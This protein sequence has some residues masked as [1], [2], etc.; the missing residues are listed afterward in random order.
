MPIHVQGLHKHYPGA[1]L[2]ALAGVSLTVGAGKIVALVGKSGAGKSTLLRCLVGLESFDQGTV[3][4]D[5]LRVTASGARGPTALVGKVGLVF[6]SFELFP[7]L[8]V[9]DNC[10]LALR[11]VQLSPRAKAEAKVRAVLEEL[12]LA[13]K[14]GAAPEL[15]S[16]GQKQRVALAR[17]LVLEPRALVYDEPT[18]ALDPALKSEVARLLRK[19]AER[20]IAQVVVTHDTALVREAAD[21]VYVLEAGRVVEEGEPRIL[22]LRG[23]R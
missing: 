4:V 7:H 10:T 21:W 22:E 19:V 20:Q 15:L 2:P 3:D 9:L 17:A 18:S 12:G 16:G 13:D 23:Y 11:K 1:A 6:Q 14:A 8:S 5:G